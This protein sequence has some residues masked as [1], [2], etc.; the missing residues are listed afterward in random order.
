MNLQN[1]HLV[2]NTRTGLHDLPV[3]INIG[4]TYFRL[5][6]TA[7]AKLAWSD[8]DDVS[9]DGFYHGDRHN[10]NLVKIVESLGSDAADSGCEL[11]IKYIPSMFSEC[12]WVHEN[13]DSGAEHIEVYAEKLLKKYL[14]T[15]KESDID[16]L[17]QGPIKE[18]LTKIQGLLKII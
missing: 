9:D 18:V 12:Y 4:T 13:D 15:L 16:A 8:A 14:G 2:S 17:S 10:P 11:K 6:Q 5:S 3:I 1:S 7:A